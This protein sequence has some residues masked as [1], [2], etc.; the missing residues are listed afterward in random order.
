MFVV[1]L[2]FIQIRGGIYSMAHQPTK[3]RKFLAGTV[4]AALVATAIVPTASAAEFSDTAGNTHEDAINALVDLGVIDGYP[5]GT[6]QPNKT[7]SRSDVVKLMGKWLVTLGYEIPADYASVQR[8]DDVSLTGNQELLQYAAL[9]NDTGV[10]NGSE[11]KLDPTGSITRENMALVLVRAF[12][13]INGTDLVAHVEGEEFDQEVTDLS[14]AKAEARPF[15]NVLDFYDITSVSEFMPKSTVTRGQF[16]TFLFK[17]SK[18]EAP[19]DSVEV[20]SVSA[21]NGKDLVVDFTTSLDDVTAEDKSNYEISINNAAA[22]ATT[23]YSVAI[24]ENDASKVNI[25]L[26]DGIALDNGAY[27]TIKVKKNVLSDKL[28]ALESDV[29]KTLTYVDTTSAAIQEVVVNGNNLEVTFNDY[30]SSVGLVKVNNV[31]KTITPIT[32]YSKTVVVVDGAKD[33]GN[34]THTVQFANVEDIANINGAGNTNVS[35]FATSNFTVTSDTVSPVV[36]KIESV[37]SDTFKITFNK[38]VTAPTVTAKKN[39]NDLTILNVNPTAATN[40]WTVDVDDN[41]GVLLYAA[42]ETSTQLSVNVSGHKALSNNVVGD[43]VNLAVTLTQDTAGP[44]VQT[45]FNEIVDLGVAGT[46]NEVINVRFNEVITLADASK[47]VLTDKDGVR[48]AINVGGATVVADG[49]LANTILQINADSI[50]TSGEINAGTYTISLGAGTVE[51][52]SSN[53]NATSTFAVTKS[54]SSSSDLAVTA[55]ASGNTITIPFATPMTSSALQL[56]N[57]KI[58]NKSLPAGTLIYFSGD[59]ETVTIELPNGS[60]ANSDNVV[61][62]VSTS[63][64]SES[65]AKLNTASRNQ[66]VSGLVDN[67]QPTLVSAKKLTSTTMELTFSENLDDATIASSAADNDFVVKVNGVT[68]GYTTASDIANDN[69]LVLTTAAYNTTQNVTVATTSVSA[70][71]DVADTIGNKLKLG[72]TVTATN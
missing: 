9:V 36:S 64:V 14:S 57:Y 58:D 34:G 21:I 35:A 40:V 47:I 69:K 52:A 28:V 38:G 66:I 2:N 24:D 16:A 39:G 26:A 12:D 19:V 63:V 48:K 37:D 60:I 25:T 33:L 45:R 4:T 18:V 65:G 61:L 56:A 71:V 10:F 59:K 68:F 49:N 50:E 44:A 32:A 54:T 29:T 72:T 70:N 46:P 6:F 67:V 5:D 11:G 27:V 43:A 31:S 55:L 62:S 51:D 30:V 41:G 7:L 3:S 17:T 42:G 13:T 23:D 22:L 53:A 15:I 20:A 8:F 1:L